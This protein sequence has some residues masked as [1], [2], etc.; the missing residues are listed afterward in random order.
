MKQFIVVDF[1]TTGNQPRQG[2]SITQIGAVV[3]E[4]GT[5]TQSYSTFVKPEKEIPS[6]ITQLTGITNEMVADAPTIEEVLPNLL[7]LLDG[8]TFVAHNA[9]FDLSFLQEALLGQ[10]YY[11]FD[12]PVLDTVELAKMLLPT[13]EGY[14]LMELSSDL[15]ITHDN[16]HQADSDAMATAELLLHLLR[17]LDDLPLITIQGLQMTITS[18]RS[19]LGRLLNELE[20][21]KLLSS[22][23]SQEDGSLKPAGSVESEDEKFDFYR[24]IAI[25]KR[26]LSKGKKREKEAISYEYEPFLEQ[27]LSVDGD[28]LAKHHTSYQRREAQE[29]MMHAVHEAFSEEKHLL[30][31]AG[32]GTGKSLGYLLPAVFWSRMHNQQVVVSTHTIHL[33]EQLFHKD[34]P[35]L[36]K[37]LPFDFKVAQLK[38]RG[39][40]LCLRKF[41]QSLEMQE[42]MSHEIQMAKA[43]LLVWLTQT[44][45]GDVEE[46]SLS[47]GGQQFWHQ[48]KSDSHSCLNRQCPWFSRCFY[49]QAKQRAREA[50]LLIVNHALLVNDLDRKAGVVPPYE[51]AIIDEAHQLDD[52]AS[53]HLGTQVSSVDLFFLMERLTV[54]RERNSLS[55]FLEELLIWKPQLRDELEE[56]R[57]QLR[58]AHQGMK[59]AS[60][61]WLQLF[62]H[63][64]LKRSEEIGESQ[65][66]VL[67]YKQGNFVGKNKKLQQSIDKVIESISTFGKTMQD[68]L[69]LMAPLQEQ[70]VPFSLERLHSDLFGLLDELNQSSAD[71]YFV[72]LDEDD[73]YVSWLEL[74][75]KTTR[76]QLFFFKSPLSVAETLHEKLFADK[77]SV[78]LTSATLTI[79]N[80]FDYFKE[81]VGLADIPEERIT[82]L[83]LPSPFAYDKQGLILIPSDFPTVSKET[84][85]IF[86]Q[87]V[88]QGCIDAVRATQGRTMILFTSYTM[89]RAVYDGMKS[90]MQKDEFTILGH[91]IDSNNRSKLVRRFQTG[92]KTVLLG[93]NSFWEGVDIPGKAL[94]CLIIVRLP[95]QP[96]NQ[97]LLQ[98]RSDKM[99]EEK[100]NP[101]MGLAL[102]HAVIRFKQGVGRL[103]RQQD[104]KGVVV[105]FDSRIVESRYG[106]T[107]IKSLPDYQVETGPWTDLNKKISLFLE[108]N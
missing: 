17:I 48:V 65:R 22:F 96:P 90:C 60:N 54:D 51:V 101:F 100:K 32:T 93:T 98:G 11:P 68:L 14:R 37:T 24:Q 44:E 88:I 70:E 95:F 61:N 47:P 75:T 78:V 25:R 7:P 23:P 94:S 76:K 21:E 31:E 73:S 46:L 42:G 83:S 80:N 77:R 72:L 56:K 86:T 36:Q 79:K 15:Q 92:E 39:N 49:F 10:G 63:W 52:V 102:P 104:D 38:G 91:G 59:E 64:G 62:Y 82:T 33:Q 97:P 9:M 107:F 66:A 20:A 50:D 1:E 81:R 28:G 58:E 5:I 89:L 12:G 84:E 19:D 103:I 99:K 3:V 34:I 43:Q 40:Y 8:R 26:R 71:L 69:Q 16:P 6:F 106:R 30:V 74:E 53:Q 41:E 67:R 13:Q 45:T 57:E 108:E 87:S 4:D 55:A 29:A 35:L 2:D 105:I 27:I 18:F 85:H